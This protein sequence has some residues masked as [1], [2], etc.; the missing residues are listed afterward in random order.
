MNYW[1]ELRHHTFKITTIYVRGQWVNLRLSLYIS[2][3]N[4][5]R[6]HWCGFVIFQPPQPVN[7]ETSCTH[8]QPWHHG[9]EI[10]YQLILTGGDL[11]LPSCTRRFFADLKCSSTRSQT[12]KTV[13]SML[14]WHRAD[15][16]VSDRSLID[17]NPM[18]FV[19]WDATSLPTLLWLWC[20]KSCIAQ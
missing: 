17:I 18:I 6:W 7:P 5:L 14:S 20:H 10:N 13:G 9:E 1:I 4:E 19:I 12:P 11:R 3:D 2:E 8:Q 16:F 15:T